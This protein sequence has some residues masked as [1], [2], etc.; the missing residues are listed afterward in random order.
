MLILVGKSCAGKDSIKK[1]LIEDGME[2]VVTYTTRPSRPGEIDGITYHFITKQEFLEKEKQ[3]FFA[4]TTSYHV[5]NGETW[6]YGSAV[7]DLKD[8]KVIIMNL[9]ELKQIKNIESLNP[10]SFYITASEET[11][12]DRLKR[13]G[14]NMH[15]AVRRLNADR[16]DFSDIINYVDFSFSSDLGLKP[17][18]LAEMILYTYK[19]IVEERRNK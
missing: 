9:E 13:R 7:G 10:V 3:G 8:D 17:E 5:A 16:E 4:E 12:W 18:I 15:E 6:Y 2:A 1:K 19:K 11:I 14:D